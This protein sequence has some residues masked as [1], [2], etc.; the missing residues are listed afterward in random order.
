MSVTT[1][2]FGLAATA[3]AFAGMAFGQAN[4][5]CQAGTTQPPAAASAI[6]ISPAVPI[7]VRSEGAT[8]LVSDELV[9]CNAA[10]A[11]STSGI[12]TAT[13]SAAGIQGV[14]SKVLSTSTGKTE[15]TLTITSG[16]D[17]YY[18]QGTVQGTTVTFGTAVAPVTFPTAAFQVQI[19]NIRVNVTGQWPN[20][21][22]PVT[23]TVQFVAQGNGLAAVTNIAAQTVGNMRNSLVVTG[24]SSTTLSAP[25]SN[26]AGTAATI[27]QY[28]VCASTGA[29]GSGASAFS[30]TIGEQFA[31]AF[32]TKSQTAFT[33]AGI[34]GSE[35]GS[36]VSATAVSGAGAGAATS[37]AAGTGVANF[38]TRIKLNFTNIPTNATVQL[39]L[40][41]TNGAFTITLQ[42]A[43]ETAA[44][45]DATTPT[46][47]VAGY[48]PVGSSGVAIYEVTAQDYTQTG[49][50]TVTPLVTYA[51]NAVTATSTPISVT[52]SYAASSSATV[53]N[54][55]TLASPIPTIP[56]FAN[57]GTPITGS[58]F[59]ACQTTLLFP[60]VTNQL[61]FETGLVIA[62][63]GK[64]NLSSTGTSVASGQAG[65]CTIQLY[66]STGAE[67]GTAPA[68]ATAANFPKSTATP[69]SIAPGATHADLLTNVAGGPF[70]GYAIA[71]CPFLY[72]KGF[73]YIAYNLLQSNGV[74][75]G[76]TA[77]LIASNRGA[78]AT[79]ATTVG[80]NSPESSGQ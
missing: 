1:K 11:G 3:A 16:A 2:I 61:G 77:D 52:V 71:T 28:L 15:A 32:K 65:A 33:V 50:F 59:A 37:Y 29:Q 6:T 4:L 34:P 24:N 36:L 51:A 44:R 56:Y 55:G 25:G 43:A 72:A 69:A 53:A 63:A 80:N 19:S 8:E 45:A 17:T 66:G 5:T 78:F 31:G 12:V 26:T 68:L 10:P 75:M 22:Q 64:D 49:S 23:E 30:I 18:Y 67:G 60:F 79:A 76:Y 35:S 7:E 38:G 9:A 70:Q 41:V 47:G 73:A 62:N 58:T 57:T 39:P 20:N 27:T 42:S 13:L 54:A 46:G 48:A 21:L 40:T 14:T 74:S